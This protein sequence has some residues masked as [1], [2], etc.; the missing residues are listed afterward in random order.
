MSNSNPEQSFINSREANEISPGFVDSI[1]Q[2]IKPEIDACRIKETDFL[3]HYSKEKVEKDIQK[4]EEQ[5][6]WF[7]ENNSLEQITIKKCADIFEYTVFDLLEMEDWMYDFVDSDGNSTDPEIAAETLLASKYDDLFNGADIIFKSGGEAGASRVSVFSIDTTFVHDE[8][9]LRKKNWDRYSLEQKGRLANLEYYR[10]GG[11]I[12]KVENIPRF[13][14]GVDMSQMLEL[15]RYLYVDPTRL[16]SEE[17]SSLKTELGYKVVTQLIVEA[18]AMSELAKNE[19][20]K[21]RSNHNIPSQ[22][23]SDIYNNL[24]SARGYF[25]QAHDKMSMILQRRNN[26]QPYKLPRQ[27][28]VHESII[29]HYH[30]ILERKALVTKLGTRALREDER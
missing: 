27:D 26:N 16:S 5:E 20:N 4:V 23:F 14:I 24:S 17:A 1:Y 19:Y 3:S 8:T 18:T 2:V 21:Q 7:A 9:V 28:R 11:F 10:S 12:G 30:S 6:H 25:G 13:I 15:A 29:N 22:Q